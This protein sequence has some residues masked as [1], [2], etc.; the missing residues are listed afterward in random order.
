MISVRAAGTADAPALSELFV[1]SWGGPIVVGHGTAYDL[2]ALPA[3]ITLGP[4]GELTGALTYHVDT[5]GLEV[6]SLDA[7]PP[8]QGT[9]T[10]LLAAA[11]EIARAAGKRRLWLITTNDNLDALRFYQRRGL[12]IIGVSPGAVDRG[13][14]LKPG[15]P[16]VGAYGIPLRDELTLEL[17]LGPDRDRRLPPR[18]SV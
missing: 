7:D 15:I 16:M 3:L 18:R 4:S 14:V 11:V 12:R 10:A 1:S 6:V 2:T 5:T 9:G 8:G 17:V 13:R